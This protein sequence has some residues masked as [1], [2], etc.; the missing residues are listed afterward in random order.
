MNDGI[1]QG[2]DK[3]LKIIQTFLSLIT[4]FPTRDAF[5]I[6]CGLCLFGNGERPQLLQL[7]YL[8]KTFTLEP[9]ESVLTN[10]HQ[11]LRKVC[12]SSPSPI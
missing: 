1:S 4:N 5:S 8:D 9:I 3:Q 10:Y 11:L 6:S 12:L 2:I 7:K